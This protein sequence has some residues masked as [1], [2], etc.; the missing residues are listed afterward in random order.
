MKI[1]FD[2][3]GMFQK[4]IMQSGF[5]FNTWALIKNHRDI[6]VR[7][8]KKLGCQSDNTLAIVQYL[9]SVPAKD[10]V[11]HSKFEVSLLKTIIKH[12]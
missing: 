2:F 7:L 12:M 10:L 3:T 4:A 1:L 9:K 5:G 6:A 11:R 8:S